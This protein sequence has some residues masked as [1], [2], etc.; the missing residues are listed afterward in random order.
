MFGIPTDWLVLICIVKT[1]QVIANLGPRVAKSKN[2][3]TP[4]FIG[5]AIVALASD[6]GVLSK[7]S[8]KVVI[9]QELSDVYGFTD[10]EGHVPQDKVMRSQ[11][12]A[13][14]RSS[15]TLAAVT[16]SFLVLKIEINTIIVF[17]S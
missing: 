8:G 12:Y 9:V 7:Y 2:A 13:Y 17:C 6:P 16:S 4:E 11:R 5:R 1:E 3:E 10:S 15:Q 14:E